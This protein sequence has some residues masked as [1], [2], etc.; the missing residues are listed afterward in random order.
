MNKQE[1]ISKIA[2]DMEVSKSKANDMLN[3]TVEAIKGALKKE[4]LDEIFNWID[5]SR[6]DLRRAYQKF[7][8][9]SANVLFGDIKHAINVG[10]GLLN[11]LNWKKSNSLFLQEINILLGAEITTKLKPF[12]DVVKEGKLQIDYES[13]SV[14]RFKGDIFNL[15]RTYFN[16]ANNSMNRG[17]ATKL[18]ILAAQD[19]SNVIIQFLDNGIGLPNEDK[20]EDKIFK[21]R[22][23]Y[24]GGQGI[25]LFLARQIIEAHNGKITAKAHNDDAVY[26]G[27][28]F[29]ITLPKE[30]QDRAIFYQ[31]D[32]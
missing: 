3:C 20:I 31:K 18:K 28:L 21:L 12:F 14:I 23:S 2:K 19:D 27:A 16:L 8:N 13:D 7:K 9:D 24:S 32:Y 26:N 17:N 25:G 29:K 22:A 10:V 5:S 15:Y 1:L 4:R 6:N 30:Q 11:L